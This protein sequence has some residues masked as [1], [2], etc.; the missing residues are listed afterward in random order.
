MWQFLSLS[1]GPSTKRSTYKVVV[2][3]TSRMFVFTSLPCARIHTGSTI[4][5]LVMFWSHTLHTFTM[6]LQ[7]VW[8]H[9]HRT[10][11][12]YA[13]ALRLLR[14]SFVQQ[15]VVSG[16]TAGYLTQYFGKQRLEL[17]PVRGQPKDKRY[18]RTCADLSVEFLS[19]N[20]VQSDRRCDSAQRLH[21]SIL[22]RI[23][24]VPVACEETLRCALF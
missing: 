2:E 4:R 21:L 22:V 13:A 18:S 14:Q 12:C 7:L 11:P 1:H 20:F 6:R 3:P 24:S 16:T 15:G 19:L 10:A 23:L 5:M 9:L 8:L 17:C